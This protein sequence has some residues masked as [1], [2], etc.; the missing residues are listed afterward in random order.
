ML[1][2][3]FAFTVGLNSPSTQVRNTFN[4][5][6]CPS[7]LN[8]VDL[9]NQ[10]SC[11]RQLSI[12]FFS[13]KVYWILFLLHRDLS[14]LLSL[15]CSDRAHGAPSFFCCDSH[16]YSFLNVSSLHSRPSLPF[17]PISIIPCLFWHFCVQHIAEPE[18]ACSPR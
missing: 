14:V 3:A 18:L 6:L 11:R 1:G 17:F 8:E 2:F 12:Q 10:S 7:P 13:S 15:I 4:A 5:T 9:M 16:A